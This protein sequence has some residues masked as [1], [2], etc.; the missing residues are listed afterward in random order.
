MSVCDVIVVIIVIVI[1][2]VPLVVNILRVKSKT[3]NEEMLE[4]LELLL[5]LNTIIITVTAIPL[6]GHITHCILP[7]HIC[8]F[9]IIYKIM[10]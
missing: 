7:L 4:H 2:L 9:N 5:L 8:I 6:G 1:I 10:V 3:K